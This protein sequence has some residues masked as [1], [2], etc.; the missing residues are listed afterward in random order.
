MR[1][2]K[3]YT[4][5]ATL[6]VLIPLSDGISQT[7]FLKKIP[8]FPGRE[9]YNVNVVF[10]D[11]RGWIWFGTDGKGLFRYDGINLEQFTT[12]DSLADDNIT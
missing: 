8:L 3:F 9:D 10:Q 6:L 12:A 5:L 1:F 11:P 4:I 7:P 2:L